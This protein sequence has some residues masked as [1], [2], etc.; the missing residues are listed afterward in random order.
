MKKWIGIE[1][2]DKVD[3]DD[4]RWAGYR[5]EAVVFQPHFFMLFCAFVCVFV[6]IRYFPIAGGQLADHNQLLNFDQV[7]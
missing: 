6:E 1:W 5:G 2:I 4:C 3:K 7:N